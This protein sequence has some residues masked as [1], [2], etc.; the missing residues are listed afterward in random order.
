MT[1][2]TKGLTDYASKELT[3]LKTQVTKLE[4][5]VNS[6][7]IESA[8]GYA[9]AIDIV[10]KLKEAGSNIKAKKESI[11]KPLNEALKST[12]NLF[13]PLEEQFERAE[14][15]VK[16]MLLA[17]KRKVDAE[18]AAKDAAI[19]KKVED[20]KMTL[21]T[22]EKKLD[23]VE[24]VDQTTRGNVGE[25]QVRKIKK[26]RIT[27]EAALPRQYLIPDQVAIR[28][29]ALSGIAIPGVEVYE[30]ETIAAVKY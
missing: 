4:N 25:V 7:T 26:V 17:Y 29:D 9:L 27:D 2:E 14:S 5:Q 28:R 22:A 8:E 19:A 20:G 3:V 1:I 24:R 11:T 10:S 15:I 13:A 16:Q 18:A 30:E 21:E 6:L 12:R 23:K